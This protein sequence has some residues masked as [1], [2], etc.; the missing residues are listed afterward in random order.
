MNPC[1]GQSPSAEKPGGGEDY[2]K[3]KQDGKV[4]NSI[5]SLF[6]KLNVD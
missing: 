5:R 2:D 6:G 1:G 4:T 3:V